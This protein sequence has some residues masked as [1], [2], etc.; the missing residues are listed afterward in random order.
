MLTHGEGISTTRVRH[1][2][3]Q[4]I[5]EC[6]NRDFKIMYFPFFYVFFYLF[7]V[8]KGMCLAPMYPQL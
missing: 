4:P 6:A 5:I 3:R 1:K 8:D 2:G 7:G